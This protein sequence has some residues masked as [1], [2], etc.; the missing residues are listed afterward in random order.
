[1]RQHKKGTDRSP[2]INRR[3][4]LT[5]AGLAIGAAGATAVSAATPAA[6]SEPQEPQHN[7][8]RESEHVKTYYRLASF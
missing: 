8:Y 3:R 7:G 4:L 2:Q 6:A 1:M 5:G